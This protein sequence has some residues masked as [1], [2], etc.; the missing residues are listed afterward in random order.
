MAHTKNLFEHIAA[1]LP[2]GE[3]TLRLWLSLLGC[4]T[5]VERTIRRRLLKECHA[6]LPRYDALNALAIFPEGLSMGDL[7]SLLMVSNGNVT[8]V[9]KRLNEAGFVK[10]F[11]P[12]R[13]R[14]S[15]VV[16]LTRKGR[17]EWEKMRAEYSATIDEMFAGLNPDDIAT[18]T[19]ALMA[20]QERIDDSLE[21]TEKK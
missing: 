10:L 12:E 21:A 14:R 18:L 19:A 5:S 7:A 9:I 4:F 13:D 2:P 3:N 20:A 17:D 1:N 11:T 16:K 15:Q 8:G 6:T